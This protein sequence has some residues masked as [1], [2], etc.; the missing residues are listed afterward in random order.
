[1][2]RNYRQ[3]RWQCRSDICRPK[4]F[5]SGFQASDPP[6]SLPS[7][8]MSGS[9][10]QECWLI[11]HIHCWRH[12]CNIIINSVWPDYVFA[13]YNAAASNHLCLINHG[14]DWGK[15]QNKF[16]K[17]V[18]ICGSSKCAGMIDRQKIWMILRFLSMAWHYYT[19]TTHG[20]SLTACQTCCSEFCC[21][22]QAGFGAQFVSYLDARTNLDLGVAATQHMQSAQVGSSHPR[23]NSAILQERDRFHMRWDALRP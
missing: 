20:T 8:P 7:C 16:R 3:E 21:R 9:I 19:A 22:S 12:V 5:T 15:N 1:M 6:Y 10:P 23:A 11:S 18:L 2:L 14:V 13:M 4:S 17:W